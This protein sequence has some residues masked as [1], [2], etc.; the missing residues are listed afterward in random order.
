MNQITSQPTIHQ[1]AD[2]HPG[3]LSHL[4]A[5]WPSVA[6]ALALLANVQGG[7]DSH[8]T[9]FIVILASMC[10]LAAAALGSRR[11]AWVMVGVAALAVVIARLTG[12]DPTVMLLI[13]GVGFAAFGFVRPRQV[14]RR[15]VGIQTLAFI[16]FSAIGLTAMV[17]SPVLAVLLAAGAAIGHGIWDVVHLVRDKVV[18]RTLA[19]ACLVLDLGLGIALLV[20]T[21][22]LMAS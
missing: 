15:E 16:V 5:R 12:L 21:L 11:S 7:L 10:Y 13:A 22:P 17:A 14:D 20:I 19:E 8:I 18:A 1:P 3:L 9:A 4:L 2:D 6:G